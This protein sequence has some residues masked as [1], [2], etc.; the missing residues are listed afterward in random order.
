MSIFIILYTVL[1]GYLLTSDNKSKSYLLAFRR[2][3]CL[4]CLWRWSLSLCQNSKSKPEA[5]SPPQCTH[6]YP[7]S[8]RMV[9]KISHRMLGVNRCHFSLAGSGGATDTQRK[10]FKHLFALGS[11]ILHFFFFF[12]LLM[13]KAYSWKATGLTCPSRWRSLATVCTAGRQRG[14][15]P[16]NAGPGRGPL[17]GRNVPSPTQPGPTPVF[18]NCTWHRE[19]V[20][21]GRL[22]TPFLPRKTG[23]SLRWS[24]CCSSSITGWHSLWVQ[25]K[26]VCSE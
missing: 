16:Q 3:P 13:K 19:G 4:P 26:T 1:L 8:D 9:A 5:P 11:F 12:H 2:V 15:Q 14:K 22:L 7:R 25:F 6:K 20:C 10:V 17:R 24:R 21:H 23:W 18:S